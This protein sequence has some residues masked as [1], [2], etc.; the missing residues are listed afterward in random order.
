M[1]PVGVT[2]PVV[3]WPPKVPPST[4]NGAWSIQGKRRMAASVHWRT[5]MASPDEFGDTL[6]VACRA[7]VVDH[8]RGPALGGERPGAQ[9]QVQ[10]RM[11]EEATFDHDDLGLLRVLGPAV[12]VN[13]ERLD[14]H[15]IGSAGGGRIDGCDGPAPEH[16]FAWDRQLSGVPSGTH[17]DLGQ[18]GR[19]V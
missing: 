13:Q 6:P 3:S 15:P 1:R 16:L 8:D 2:S 12:R 5:C 19:A 14:R 10:L 17:E 9:I 7:T 18:I 4:L 11:I